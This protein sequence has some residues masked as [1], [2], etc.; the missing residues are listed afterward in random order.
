MLIVSLGSQEM[1][2]PYEVSTVFTTPNLKMIKVMLSNLPELASD[3]ASIQTQSDARACA[4]NNHHSMCLSHFQFYPPES[5]LT[6]PTT[7]GS[8]SHQVMNILPPENSTPPAHS[9]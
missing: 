9:H 3:R 6:P 1:L 8:V 7:L 2:Q 5:I 4:L